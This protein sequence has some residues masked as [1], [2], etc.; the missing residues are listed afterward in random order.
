MS[1]PDIDPELAALAD[2]PMR[3]PKTIHCRGTNDRGRACTAKITLSSGWANTCPSCGS[4]YNG[5][6]QR[7]APRSQWGEETGE[8]F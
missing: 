2:R 8:S 3:E 4:E 5:S 7:L 6:G 1:A